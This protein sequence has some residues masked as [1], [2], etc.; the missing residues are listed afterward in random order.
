MTLS[1]CRCGVTFDTKISM[2]VEVC[3]RCKIKARNKRNR[4]DEDFIADKCNRMDRMASLG[5]PKC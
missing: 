5:V 2:S 3:D 1:L 4:K